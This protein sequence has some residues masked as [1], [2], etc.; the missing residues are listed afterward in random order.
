LRIGGH[1]WR[2]IVG[3]GH[4]PEHASLYCA[5]LDVL[6]SGDMLL[7]RISTNVSAMSSNPDGDPI[8]WFLD[9]IERYA[10]CPKAPWC[11]PRTG[12]PSAASTPASP[13]STGTTPSA[14]RRSLAACDTPK[15]ACEL[16]PTLFNRELDAHQI[17]FAMG[18]SIAHLNYLEHAGRVRRTQD[19]GRVPFRRHAARQERMMSASNRPA[20]PPARPAGS[21]QH[22]R[23]GRPARLQADHRAHAAPD[24]AGPQAAP[25]TSWASPRPSWT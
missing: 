22:L 23:R 2:V 24:E 19:A 11:C 14:S 21:R 13:S 8:G 12:G 9:S 18:E 20:N 16:I 7:P 6:I 3:Y 1:D 25:A 15:S 10:N 4:S 17:M 5:E